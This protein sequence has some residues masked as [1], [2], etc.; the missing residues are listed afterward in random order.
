M[1][2]GSYIKMFITASFKSACPIVNVICALILPA[3]HGFGYV[4]GI[5]F[6]LASV[7][8][9]PSSAIVTGKKMGTDIQFLIFLAGCITFEMLISYIRGL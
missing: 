1:I 8:I 9:I 6:V 2:N 3:L 5:D 4:N 7:K